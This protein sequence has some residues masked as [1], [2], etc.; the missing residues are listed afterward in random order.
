V[1]LRHPRTAMSELE[2]KAH[3]HALINDFEQ[4][5]AYVHVPRADQD[6]A[7]AVGLRMLVLR[8]LVQESD[9]LY[10]A[11]DAEHDMLRYYANSIA[12]FLPE[13]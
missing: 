3:A 4:R 7:A 9:G 11:C 6:Y 13:S 2:I 8:H 5:G 1:F 12:H 10:R